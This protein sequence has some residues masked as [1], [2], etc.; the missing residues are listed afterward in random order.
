MAAWGTNGYAYY[1]SGTPALNVPPE[2]YD[3][4]E[5]CGED[6]PNEMY[7]GLIAIAIG[8]ETLQHSRYPCH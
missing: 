2:F 6:N 8:S 4:V 1:D 5:S 3:S 7:E